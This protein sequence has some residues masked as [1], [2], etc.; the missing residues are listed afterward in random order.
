M[1][2]FPD[3]WR[4]QKNQAVLNWPFP[5]LLVI[6]VCGGMDL[7]LNAPRTSIIPSDK[8]NRFEKSLATELLLSITNSLSQDFWA[9][10]VE[11]LEAAKCSDIFLDS[12]REI[13]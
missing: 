9:K 4:S 12:L 3:Y 6:D 5:V 2:L 11:V 8:W 1:T 13:G 10:L 7:D